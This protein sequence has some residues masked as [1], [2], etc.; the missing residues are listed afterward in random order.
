MPATGFLLLLAFI[1]LRKAEGLDAAQAAL[2]D[3]NRGVEARIAER[4][5][6]LNASVRRQELATSA[7]G[8]GIFEWDPATGT[9]HWENRRMYDIFARDPDKGPPSFDEFLGDCI[10]PEDHAALRKLAAEAGRATPATVLAA[11]AARASRAS[12]GWN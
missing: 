2:R 8:F 9:S 5:V 3:L 11:I 7:A 1:G 12:A 6:E 10:T 4:T